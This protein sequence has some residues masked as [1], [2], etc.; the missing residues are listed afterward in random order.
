MAAV[1]HSC[2][3]VDDNRVPVAPV[4]IVFN[5]VADWDI[6]GVAGAMDY[7]RFIRDRR[8]PANYPYTAMTYTGFG[9][10]LLL[11]DVMGNP[12]AYDLCC[13][14]ECS[15]NT[16][17]DIDTEKMQARCPDCGSTYEVF[18]L[19]GSPTSG[20]AAEYG[21]GLRNYRVLPGRDGAYRVV[22]N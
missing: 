20:P 11:T 10:V 13:P 9:G 4:N 8:V 18:S 16:I 12:R 17:V 22:T 1:V 7:R 5:T 3:T 19:N 2:H 15:R 6:Y 21:Y 14:V